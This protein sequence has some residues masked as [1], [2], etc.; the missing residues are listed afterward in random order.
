MYGEVELCFSKNER[1][2][3][4]APPLAR[5]TSTY[6]VLSSPAHSAA[7]PSALL[8]SSL[9]HRLHTYFGHQGFMWSVTSI[10]VIAVRENTP[11]FRSQYFTTFYTDSRHLDT[12][13]RL[14]DDDFVILHTAL[15][16]VVPFYSYLAISCRLLLEQCSAASLPQRH[17]FSA[18]APDRIVLPPWQTGRDDEPYSTTVELSASSTLRIRS[19]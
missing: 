11:G 19:C 17:L 16:W 18:V 6:V 7:A 14:S 3:P 13:S 8:L 10:I 1:R 4:H 15:E 12:R 2:H 5:A 9:G